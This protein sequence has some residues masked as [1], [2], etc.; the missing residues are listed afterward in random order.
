MK[1]KPNA[2]TPANLL[3]CISKL[4]DVG[5]E[6]RA[7]PTTPIKI[8]PFAPSFFKETADATMSYKQPVQIALF[9]VGTNNSAYD[10]MAL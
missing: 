9:F 10:D 2:D 8:E 3:G 6:T 5:K 4:V 1:I 7:I